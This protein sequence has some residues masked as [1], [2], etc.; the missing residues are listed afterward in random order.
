MDVSNI[1]NIEL[2]YLSID[3]YEELKQIMIEIYSD[4]P[5]GY[6]RKEQIQ[7]LINIFPEGQVV[8]KVNGKLAAC[9]LSI[10]VDY[11][12]LGDKHTY[13]QITRIISAHTP[14]KATCCTV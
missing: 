11:K 12:K 13:K 3:D 2:S 6:W 7:K 10:I 9:A 14:R 5:G 1:E 4:K 8:I